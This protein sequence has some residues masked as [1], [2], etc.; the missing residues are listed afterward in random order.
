MIPLH[1]VCCTWNPELPDARCASIR[2]QAE[3][4]LGLRLK[5][6][7][8]VSVYA[9]RAALDAA[10]LAMLRLRSVARLARVLIGRIQ[11]SHGP[12]PSLEKGPASW[13]VS[14]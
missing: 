1:H 4:H 11:Q 3:R 12:C 13:P 10:P 5:G 8:N 7:K 2:R 14:A 6:L 9:V